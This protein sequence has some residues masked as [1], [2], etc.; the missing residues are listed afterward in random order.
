MSGLPDNYVMRGF[1]SIKA[2][3]A[4]ARA[5]LD[6]L[7]RNQESGNQYLLA[8]SIPTAIRVKLDEN[9]SALGGIPFRL[10]FDG[11]SSLVKVIPSFAHGASTRRL[12]ENILFSSLMVGVPRYDTC[13]ASTTTYRGTTSNKGKQPDD[14]FVP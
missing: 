6:E 12:A 9:K 5:I 3:V 11:A 4:D 13:W 14:C 2:L 10:M 8:L 1:S 7:E